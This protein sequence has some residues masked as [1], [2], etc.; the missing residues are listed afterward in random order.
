VPD[1]ETC[2]P[3]IV[4]ETVPDEHDIRNVQAPAI[5][6]AL[7]SVIVVPVT[8]RTLDVRTVPVAGPFI[9]GELA[10]LLWVPATDPF[11][12]V[13]V[14]AVTPVANADVLVPRL[15]VAVTSKS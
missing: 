12:A 4:D 8:A 10:P 13:G 11:A 9:S 7:G 5:V 15:F 1:P 3:P 2:D 6:A 14:A